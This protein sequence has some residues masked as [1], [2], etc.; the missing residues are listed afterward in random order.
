ML[1]EGAQ[2]YVM[3]PFAADE[4]RARVSNLVTMKRTRQLLQKELGSEVHDVELLAREVTQ[5]KRE[6]QN[7]MDSMRVARQHA[8]QQSRLKSGFLGMMSHELRTPLAA[9]QLQLERL[10]RSGAHE[11]PPDKQTLVRR[12]SASIGRVHALIEGLLQYARIES[13]RFNARSENVDISRLAQEVVDELQML[14]DDKGVVLKLNIE[15]DTSLVR[16]ILLNLID[17]GL[18]STEHGQVRIT[19]RFDER[20]CRLT[21]A[22]TGPGIPRE[23]QSKLFA[24][25][26]DDTARH[27]QLP[28]TGLSLALVRELVTA[29]G[30]S[31]TVSSKVGHGTKFSVRIPHRTHGPVLPL[32]VEARQHH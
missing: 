23:Q 28:G 9:L 11:L 29:L 5:Q 32:A 31:I 21:V 1:R 19:I 15:D 18:R 22:D 14:A 24:S 25:F 30:G 8:E 12:M 13:G 3:K 10:L 2:D 16:L 27:K 7:A 4:L 6:L 20:S 26:D 17:N